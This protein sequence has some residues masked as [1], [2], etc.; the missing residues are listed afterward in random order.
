MAEICLYV[1]KEADRGES[2]KVADK[3]E[4]LGKNRFIVQIS[5]KATHL[6]PFSLYERSQY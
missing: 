6:D 2:L 5:A 1:L 4:E 3:Q